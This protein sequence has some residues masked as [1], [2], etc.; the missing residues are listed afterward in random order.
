MTLCVTAGV[1]CRCAQVLLQASLHQRKPQLRSCPAAPHQAPL[2]STCLEASA[3]RIQLAEPNDRPAGDAAACAPRLAELR[4]EQCCRGLRSRHR[5][6]VVCLREARLPAG[7]AP[8]PHF[9]MTSA[10]VW[11]SYAESN[12]IGGVLPTLRACRLWTCSAPASRYGLQP[13]RLLPLSCLSSPCLTHC[14][15]A[16]PPACLLRCPAYRAWLL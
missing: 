5:A 15:E 1:P 2:L 9:L 11:Q 16:K 12:A 8:S 4:R 7:T 14:S 3:R 10:I 6:P 13:H